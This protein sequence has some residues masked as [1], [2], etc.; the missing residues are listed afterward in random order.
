ML[1]PKTDTNHTQEKSHK[2]AEFATAEWYFAYHNFWSTEQC[3]FD[4]DL[5]IYGVTEE[6]VTDSNILL[7][8]H[9]GIHG[10]AG[11]HIQIPKL[12]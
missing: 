9:Q 4:Q 2:K 12:G 6:V 1:L 5:S 7:L 10:T 3:T 11:Q 8:S